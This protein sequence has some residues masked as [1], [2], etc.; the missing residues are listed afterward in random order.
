VNAAHPGCGCASWVAGQR[1]G[2]RA[3]TIGPAL[4]GDRPSAP[5]ILDQEP[6]QNIGLPVDNGSA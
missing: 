1:D 3:L 5:A 2:K 6:L 4:D